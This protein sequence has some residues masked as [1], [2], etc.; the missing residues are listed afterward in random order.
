MGNLSPGEIVT[1]VIG[2]ILALAGAVSTIGSAVEK[3]VKV[4]RAAK[5]PER[6]QNAEIEEIKDRLN[7]VERKLDNDKIQI[8]DAKECNHVLTKGMLALLEHGINGN[9]IDQMREAKN[10]VEAYLINH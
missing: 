7:K 4:A 3:I 1:L 10:G 8:A 2:G 6:Q 9:N 5:A